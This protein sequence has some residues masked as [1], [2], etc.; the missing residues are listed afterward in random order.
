MRPGLPSLQVTTESLAAFCASAEFE[1]LLAALLMESMESRNALENASFADI[2][3]FA[4]AQGKA[5]AINRI[6]AEDFPSL[7]IKI[8]AVETERDGGQ[9]LLFALKVKRYNETLA[10]E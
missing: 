1:F 7:L 5:Q 8:C 10:R 9:S 4:R 6:L 2:A 3:E